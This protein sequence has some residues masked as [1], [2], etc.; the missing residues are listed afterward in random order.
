MK[1]LVYGNG[2]REHA[3]A[4]KLHQSEKIE[5]IFAISPNALMEK[6]THPLTLTS[7][8]EM[9]NF[10]RKEKVD[11]VVIGPEKPLVDGIVDIFEEHGIQA[12][13]PK[14][15]FTW[16]ESSKIRSKEFNKRNEIPCGEAI[17]VENMEEAKKAIKFFEAPYVLKADGLAGG[18]GVLIVNNAQEAL[19]KA[20]EM[21]S[22]KFGQASKRILFEEYLEGEELSAICLFD[23][24]TLL[25]LEFVRDHKKLWD[26]DSGPNTGG[27]GAYSPVNID[28]KMEKT[29]FD[30][31]NKV[32]SALKRE[33]IRYH[34]VLYVGIMLTRK[35]AKVLE[36]NVRFGDP[37]AQALMV[38]LQ[39][40]LQTVFENVLEENLKMVTLKWGE[41]SNVLT[42]ASEGYPFAPKK[43]VEISDFYEL[44]EE[45]NVT[46]FGGAIEKKDGKYICNGGRV[47]SVAT[48]GEN[49]HRRTLEFAER[50]NF[51]AKVYR[52]DVGRDEE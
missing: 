23:G 20:K 44:A 51:P 31:L 25:P 36:Y 42:I 43:D 22:G 35:G 40:D 50:L 14:K 30:L 46:V 27:M 3:L 48:V 47:L 16:L 29:V 37:E 11:F 1:V 8:E 21:L 19:E 26:G 6:I 49:A 32:E 39:S 28:D 2:A 38:R 9:A 12:F 24:K 18:K 4:W 7:Y 52:K 13:G 15:S 45:L 41:P 34:G 33:N 5:K 17:K 10:C